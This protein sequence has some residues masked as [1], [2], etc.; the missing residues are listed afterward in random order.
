MLRP[1]C[2]SVGPCSIRFCLSRQTLAASLLR[3]RIP[4]QR[5][6]GLCLKRARCGPGPVQVHGLEVMWAWGAQCAHAAGPPTSGPHPRR[7]G[8]GTAEGG[9]WGCGGATGPW[10][11]P[12]RPHSQHRRSAGPAKCR[13]PFDRTISPSTGLRHPPQGTR[14]AGTSHRDGPRSPTK[15]T[16]R[17]VGRGTGPRDVW[18]GNGKKGSE[19]PVVVYAHHWTAVEGQPTAIE[20]NAFSHFLMIKAGQQGQERDVVP[21]PWAPRLICSGTWRPT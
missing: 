11:D 17:R 7:S 20:V 2:G 5:G 21:G 8:G 1:A 16:R 14:S 13:G 10:G 4:R 15:A 3:N 9:L 12:F 18:N 19:R 6:G